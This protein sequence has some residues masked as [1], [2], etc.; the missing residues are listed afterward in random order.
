M[1]NAYID[2]PSYVYLGNG[3]F[4][5][6]KKYDR[7]DVLSNWRYLKNY[8]LEKNINLNTIDFWDKDKA[9][10]EDIYI[11]FEHKNFL[12][13]VH[14]RFKNKRYPAIKLDK[15]K[16]RILFQF[17][18]PITMPEVYMNIDNLLKIYDKVFFTCKLNNPKIHYFHYFQTYDKILLDYWKD[19]NRTF[20]TMI[21]S[22][23][24]I[25]NPK[26]FLTT[27]I[28]SGKLP[29]LGYKELL[30]ER[31]KAVEFFSRTNDIDLYGS[32]WDK[33]P[34]FPYWFYKKAIQKV[35]K[36][37]V[38]SKYSTFSKYN[39]S[40]CFENCV[41]PGY[42]TEKIFDCFFVGTI[43]IYY[44]APDIEKY[45]PK[46]CFIDR[47]DFK[48]YQ[49]LRDFLKSLTESEIKAYKEN[50]RQFLESEQYKPFTKEYFAKTF[51]EACMN[52]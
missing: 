4:K 46:D 47:R 23:K 42:I 21:S 43:P 12:R 15:F 1:I 3:L 50:A 24:K 51:I 31:I 8:C 6:D 18:P 37:Q 26:K 44:G 17:E 16:K 40:I 39:F 35:Y 45:I 32:D 22:N 34:S 49:E 20:L 10:A 38:Q 25:R 11:S 14:W 33:C 36:G 13:K 27:I 52:E 2:P 48:N 5:E 41:F 28:S 9:T 19:S 29:H 7:D 30:S